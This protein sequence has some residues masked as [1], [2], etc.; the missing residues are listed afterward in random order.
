MTSNHSN[1]MDTFK[2]VAETQRQVAEVTHHALEQVKQHYKKPEDLA[3]NIESQGTPVYVLRWGIFGAMVLMFL[4]FEP[5]FIMPTGDKRYARLIR[6]LTY[7]AD[8]PG[9]TFQHGAFVLTPKL[10]TVGYLA[11]QL[12]HWLGYRSGLPGYEAQDQALY[13]RFWEQNHGVVGPEVE[14]M[15]VD[16]IIRLKNAINR[17]M[18]ALQFMQQLVQEIF[19]PANQSLSN[20][21]ANA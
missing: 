2:L 21:N 1:P 8:K 5:G 4:G 10:F 13:R 15:S 17:D 20:G 14:H 6:F 19:V 16:D 7:M 3:A 11:H 18:E 9:C 12:H